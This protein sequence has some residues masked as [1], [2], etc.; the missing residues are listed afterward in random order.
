MLYML[1]VAFLYYL[2]M[3]IVCIYFVLCIL[4]YF[5]CILVVRGS[6]VNMGFFLQAKAS[7]L[8]EMLTRPTSLAS[9][10]ALCSEVWQQYPEAVAVTS[11]FA[12][13]GVVIALMKDVPDIRGDIEFKISSFSVQLGAKKMFR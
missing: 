5:S 9:L 13:F 2:L 1:E 6:L 10:G 7:V 3:C 11:F 12:V 4:L 8:G